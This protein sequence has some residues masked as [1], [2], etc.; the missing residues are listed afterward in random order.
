MKKI[1][2]FAKVNLYLEVFPKDSNGYH[3]INS[4]IT[5][6]KDLYDEI[7]IEKNTNED[8]VVCN[9]KELEKTNFIYQVLKILRKN[10]VIKDFYKI[11]LKKNIPIGAGL[12]GGTSDA[13]SLAKFFKCDKVSAEQ[14]CKKIGYDSYFFYSKYKTALVSGYGELVSKYKKKIT[15]RK[16]DLIFT[17]INCDTKKVY[18]AFDKLDYEHTEK[19]NNL[20]K[21]ACKLYPILNNYLKIGQ[22][23]GSG[24]TF[25]YKYKIENIKKS[26]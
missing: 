11:T 2:A 10:L 6:V 19:Q 17:N 8:I 14:I 26:F 12:G 4:L 21:A 16:K 3:K 18:E 5:Y 20:T 9:I 24:S 15:I 7:I 23:S 13:I 1:K 25:I 22:M